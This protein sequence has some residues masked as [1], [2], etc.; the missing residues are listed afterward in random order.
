[1]FVET[2]RQSCAVESTARA[3]PNRNIFVLFSSPVGVSTDESLLDAN[4][5]I[6]ASYPN[7]HIL[8]VDLWRYAIGTPLEEWINSEKIFHSGFFNWHLS[9]VL[10]FITLYR[11][12]GIYADLDFVVK[13]SFD[14]LGE[15]FAGND[16]G[17]VVAPGLMHL[18]QSG[19]GHIIAKRCM[20]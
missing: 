17:D 18:S 4:I 20:R 9:D 19:I 14:D 8:N 16:W 5:A 7:I 6:L 10:R 13:K 15:N 12:G 1:M 11:Y 3:N 2:H